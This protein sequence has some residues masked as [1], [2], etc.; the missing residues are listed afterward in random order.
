MESHQ[1]HPITNDD[2]Q[3]LLAL[4]DIRF[5]AVPEDV[6]E[7]IAAIEDVSQIDHLILVAANAA[8]WTDFLREVREPGFRIVGQGFDPLPERDDGSA[9]RGKHHGK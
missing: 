1:P 2:R 4:L 7:A 6:S 8:S 3:D 5:G 9:K